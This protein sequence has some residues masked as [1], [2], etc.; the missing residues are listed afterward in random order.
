[1]AI[2]TQQLFERIEQLEAHAKEQD[3]QLRWLT[4]AVQQLQRL[5][6]PTGSSTS[7]QYQSTPSRTDVGMGP[8]LNPTGSKFV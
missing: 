4:S 7:P 3:Q 1:M 5:V 6:A 8:V 2:D